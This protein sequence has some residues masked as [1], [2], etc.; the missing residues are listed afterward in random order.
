MSA[1][2]SERVGFGG[3]LLQR[4]VSV[5]A[6]DVVTEKEEGFE[7]E[8]DNVEKFESAAMEG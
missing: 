1:A 6:A 5:L 8:D 7:R 2:A 3:F 4:Q